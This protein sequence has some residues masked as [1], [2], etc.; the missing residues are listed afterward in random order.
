MSPFPVVR[1]AGT[2]LPHGAVIKVLSVRSPRGAQIRVRC[3]GNG[4]PVRSVATTSATRLVRFHRFERRLRRH[5]PQGVRQAGEPDR[6][7]HELPDPRGRSPEA[8]GPVCVPDE[9]L[10]ATFPM[11]RTWTATLAALAFG[12]VFLAASVALGGGAEQGSGDRVPHVRLSS[13]AGLPAL[14]KDRA[15]ELAQARR[16]AARRDRLRARR[17]AAARRTAAAELPASTPAEPLTPA[18]PEPVEPPPV[19]VPAPAPTPAPPPP[20]P[21]PETFDDSG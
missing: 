7:V 3:T 21:T 16:R 12:A 18:T 15:V 11:T 4:C 20:P 10:P 9:A 8:G 19:A 6:Q 17:R 1:I 2:V 13:V 14:A 5:P